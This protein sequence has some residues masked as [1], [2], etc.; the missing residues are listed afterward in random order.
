MKLFGNKRRRPAP[1]KP[2]QQA[3]QKLE[4]APL[5]PVS[6]EMSDDRLNGRMKARLLLAGSI[7]IFVCAIVMCLTL[8]GKS[9]EPVVFPSQAHTEDI[10]YV[11]GSVQPSTVKVPVEL[12]APVSRNASDRLNIL[13]IGLN[14]SDKQMDAIMLLSVDMHT[15][16]AAL[17]SFPR[18]TYVAGSYDTPKLSLVY[19]E[20]DDGKGRGTQAVREKVKNMVGFEA[21]YYFVLDEASVTAMT[22]LVGGVEFTVPD[23][24]K[25]STLSAGAKR[26]SG[27]DAMQLL[28]YRDGYTD[29]EAASAAVQRDF[30]LKLLDRLLEN[31]EKY[32]ENAETIAAS[33]D[34]D[35]TAE[36][37]AYLAYLLENVDTAS[38]FSGTLPGGAI[39]VDGVSYYE[40]NPE[41]AL[42][43]LNEHFNPLKG[44]LSIYDINFRQE[45]GDS[46]SGEYDSYGFSSSTETNN[47]PSETKS[48]ENTEENTD[49]STDGSTDESTDE[50]SDES[51]EETTAPTEG[52]EP[53]ETSSEVPPE[54]DPPT[55]P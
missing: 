30:L 38:V 50:S 27:M 39:K 18:D 47:K 34:T 3:P 24:P 8:I 44:A 17:L 46:G 40:I 53:T 52:P 42:E 15:A 35:L 12:T 10:E 49:E 16:E 54:T 14:P 19:K 7:C 9:A 33:A 29:A 1:Q 32:L 26:L 11:I 5:E 45:T 41:E 25:Y 23:E 28:C 6:E 36:N 37:L 20:A 2:Q 31:P 21:D 48:T 55:E 13:L 51:S 22:E 43:M 4:Q